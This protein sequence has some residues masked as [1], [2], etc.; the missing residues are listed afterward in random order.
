M[1]NFRYLLVCVPR[2]DES[3][4]RKAFFECADT[5]KVSLE[6]TRL[7]RPAPLSPHTIHHISVNVVPSLLLNFVTATRASGHVIRPPP[8][9][10]VVWLTP[11]VGPKLVVV[12]GVIRI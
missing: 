11:L 9:D 6:V 4:N 10:F 3:L 8:R 1:Q 5:T 2:L 7:Q 12:S